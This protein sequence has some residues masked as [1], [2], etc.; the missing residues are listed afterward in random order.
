MEY[1]R[2]LPKNALSRA[3][4]R[5]A[6]LKVPFGV[7]E[8]ARDWF[9][10]TYQI[11]MNEAELPIERYKTVGELFTRRL[12]PGARPIGDGIVHPCDGE[13]TRSGLI[14]ERGLLQTKGIYYSLNDFVSDPLADKDFSG[15]TFVT[16][17]LCPRDYHR[18]HAPIDG[19]VE[20]VI[21]VPGRL[22]P[23][24]P[25]SVEHISQLFLLNERIV[26]RLKTALGPV[27]I[28][29]I[30]ATNVGN[31]EVVFDKD[32]KCN[33]GNQSVFRRKYVP[34]V[35]LKKGDEMGVFHMGSSVVAIYPQNV[36]SVLPQSKK[37]KMGS[38]L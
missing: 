1:I 30:G 33:T 32:I 10:K 2:F 19:E 17:Y 26:F 34:N 31:I 4:G 29:M 15:G 5:L 7:S 18:V 27:A 21:H 9:I 13:I 37:V 12:K 6:Q 23:V 36:V 35:Q 3:V 20:E 14:T 22:W 28:V 8:R 16:Y 25:W 24:N 38:S 11:D